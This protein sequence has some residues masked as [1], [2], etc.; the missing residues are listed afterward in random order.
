[1]SGTED[2]KTSCENTDVPTQAVNPAML[3]KAPKLPIKVE[4]SQ[5]GDVYKRQARIV[6]ACSLTEERAASSS[7]RVEIPCSVR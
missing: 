7:S 1:M 3:V 6:S 2:K 5:D 4:F